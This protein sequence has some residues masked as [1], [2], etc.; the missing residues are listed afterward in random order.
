MYAASR[1]RWAEVELALSESVEARSS[2]G[3]HRARAAGAED[4]EQERH[5]VEELVRHGQ[6]QSTASV[7]GRQHQR[8]AR[9]E[10]LP[11]RPPKGPRRSPSRAPRC[12]TLSKKRAVPNLI[13]YGQGG[14][15]LRP[16]GPRICGPHQDLVIH[17][18]V[19]SSLRNNRVNLIYGWS[20][21]AVVCSPCWSFLGVAVSFCF[22]VSWPLDDV[23]VELLLSTHRRQRIPCPQRLA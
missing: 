6:R 12:R 13:R 10:S 4:A 11:S 20:A 15:D 17:L 7:C 23:L 18:R 16:P 21:M 8:S 2:R 3:R 22:I 1:R 9:Q 14:I 19:V 5:E